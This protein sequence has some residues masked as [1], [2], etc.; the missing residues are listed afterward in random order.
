MFD[1]KGYG[2]KVVMPSSR[3]SPDQG[4]GAV[5]GAGRLACVASWGGEQ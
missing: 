1:D 5:H 2:F 4:L 3:D